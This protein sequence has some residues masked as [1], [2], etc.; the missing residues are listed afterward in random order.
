MRD[1]AADHA[2]WSPRKESATF[3]LKVPKIDKYYEVCLA[4]IETSTTYYL[5]QDLCSEV[6]MRSLVPRISGTNLTV[7]PD[8]S[9]VAVGWMAH[10]KDNNVVRQISVRE[11]GHSGGDTI[12][13]SDLFNSSQPSARFYTI[14]SLKPGVGYV[15]CFITIYGDVK[16]VKTE[17]ETKVQK[18]K[19]Y[20]LH[21]CSPGS[22]SPM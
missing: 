4:V 14:D 10:E 20:L 8:I 13:V 18:E 2:D 15:V 21:E 1:Y 19:M 6:D 7:V 5:H 9:S 12:L 16:E 11:F 3:L 17:V 22:V